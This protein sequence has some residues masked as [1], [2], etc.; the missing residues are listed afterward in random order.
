M[1]EVSFG[2]VELKDGILGGSCMVGEA[3]RVKYC[4]SW[5]TEET[6]FSGLGDVFRAKKC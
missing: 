3:E 6:F 5:K 2:G 1:E 4:L